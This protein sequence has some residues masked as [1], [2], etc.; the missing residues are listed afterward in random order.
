MLRQKEQLNPWRLGKLYI[1]S[2][3]ALLEGRREES[4]AASKELTEA[5]FRDPEGIYYLARQVSYLGQQAQALDLL[6]RSVKRGFFCYP[7]MVRD[8]WLDSL[9]GCQEFTGLL[10]TARDLHREAL[11][12]FLTSGGDTLLG[13]PPA[14]GA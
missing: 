7:A 13:I 12:S 4:L 11:E 6:S 10:R 1:T 2:L 14:E 9:R 5:T 3:R 8:P